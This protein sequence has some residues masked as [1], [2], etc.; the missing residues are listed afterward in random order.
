MALRAVAVMVGFRLH[1]DKRLVVWIGDAIPQPC[2]RSGR[3]VQAR[4]DPGR[5]FVIPDLIHPIHDLDPMHRAPACHE[6][7]REHCI[8]EAN[9][10]GIIHH[11]LCTRWGRGPPISTTIGVQPCVHLIE[12]A[13]ESFG[14][15]ADPDPDRKP[16]GL[17]NCLLRHLHR[18][19]RLKKIWRAVGGACRSRRSRPVISTLPSSV[20]RRRRTFRSAISS[21]RVR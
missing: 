7:A 1:T 12:A 17:A 3:L 16:F 11:A 5:R 13:T 20:K 18:A 4:T 19:T 10:E 9:R 21:S 6:G 8:R 14:R 2:A 15:Y